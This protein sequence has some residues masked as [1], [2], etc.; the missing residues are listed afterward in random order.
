VNFTNVQISESLDFYWYF[1]NGTEYYQSTGGSIPIA[2]PGTWDGAYASMPLGGTPAINVTGAW[3]VLAYV[4]GAEILDQPFVVGNYTSPLTISFSAL[5]PVQNSTY[6][7]INSTIYY[8]TSSSQVNSYVLFTNVGSG[9]Y[10]LTFEFVTPQGTDYANV[11]AGNFTGPTPSDYAYSYLDIIGYPA[12][13]N[14]GWWKLI[15]YVN[16]NFSSPALIQLFNISG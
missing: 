13:S 9:T 6:Y 11:N 1:P 3:Y 12:A 15:L 5:S 16:N 7:P 10:N 14:P 2:P 4:G 8:T